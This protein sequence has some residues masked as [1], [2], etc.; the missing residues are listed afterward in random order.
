MEYT[1]FGILMSITLVLIAVSHFRT[2][3]NVRRE[4]E[5]QERLRR[6]RVELSEMG[7]SED[8]VP[9]EG[10]TPEQLKWKFSG[11]SGLSDRGGE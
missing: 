4:S 11:D 9:L 3:G 8:F 5:E 7:F 1:V 10:I 6:E 2:K